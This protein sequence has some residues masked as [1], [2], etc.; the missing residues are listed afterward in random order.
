MNRLYL[1]ALRPYVKEDF[2][3]V[4]IGA[5]DGIDNDPLFPL[6]KKY[7]WKGIAVEP[8]PET[9]RMLKRNLADYEGIIFENVA[10]GENGREIFGFSEELIKIK[11]E[12]RQMC[13]FSLNHLNHF[14]R[15][16]D[17]DMIDHPAAHTG[18]KIPPSEDLKRGMV[19]FQVTSVGFNELMEKHHVQRVDFIN[20]DTENDDFDIMASIDMDKYAPKIL[21][22]ET[23][24][25]DSEKRR[26]FDEILKKYNYTF[27]QPF[28][29]VSEVFIK[30]K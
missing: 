14:M 5:N 15:L 28:T 18:A 22:I 12:L 9:F 19:S 30:D 27:L 20:I 23:N 17:N 7:R 29:V 3:F 13:S 8:I 26:V 1:K 10:I 21:C 11:P 6:I 2:F 4:N 16:A 25:F 24:T